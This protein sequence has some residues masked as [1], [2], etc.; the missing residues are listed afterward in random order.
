M[1]SLFKRMFRF[2][3]ASVR[4]I[5]YIWLGLALRIRNDRLLE[6]PEKCLL[7]D[8]ELHRLPEQFRAHF[9]NCF[10]V[11]S[12]DT[13]QIRK[14]IDACG[15]YIRQQIIDEADLACEH[16]FDLL[17]SGPTRLGKSIDWHYDLHSSTPLFVPT[18]LQAYSSS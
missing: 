10:F 2:A 1:A 14:Q 3:N 5:K 12:H 4:E 13:K 9:D 8:V 18:I 17:G 7:S 6:R 11:S 16:I 15:Q